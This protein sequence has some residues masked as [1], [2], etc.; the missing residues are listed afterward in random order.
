LM[1]EK[2]S[3]NQ[4]EFYRYNL[5]LEFSFFVIKEKDIIGPYQGNTVN[6][7][8]GGMYFTTD[9]PLLQPGSLLLAEFESQSTNED[10]STGLKT[11]SGDFMARVIR[12]ESDY[13]AIS[14]KLYSFAVE[15][16][17]TRKATQDEIVAY[18][19]AYAGKSLYRF[20]SKRNLKY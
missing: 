6:L 16:K 11:L 7:G 8:G 9:C 14:K 19:N 3:S 5:N 12:E 13:I 4:R 17:F 18:L 1:A 10:D 15:F 2:K 20:R